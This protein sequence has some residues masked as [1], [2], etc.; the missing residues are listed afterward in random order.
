MADSRDDFGRQI[1][2]LYQHLYDL[3]YLRTHAFTERLIPDPA[4]PR[5]EKAWR[6]H[7]LLLEV[8]KELDPGPEAPAFSR[9]WRRHRLMVLRYVDG[10]DPQ[11]VAREV[12]VSRRQYYREHDAALDA[13]AD[14]LWDR[15]ATQS[16]DLQDVIQPVEKASPVS[17]LELLRLET[18][19]LAQAERYTRV[20]QVATNVL[21]LFEERLRQRA[22]Q[23][24]LSLPPSTPGVSFDRG[25]LRQVL[26]GMLGYLIER[27]SEATIDVTVKHEASGAC[28]ALRVD[29]PQAVREM[30]AAVARERIEAFEEMAALESA[31]VLPVRTGEAIT[32]FDLW[33]PTEL[34]RT[35]L[36]VDDNED[37]LQLFQRYLIP[38]QYRVATAQTARAGLDLAIKLKPDVITLDLMMPEQ[39]GWDLLQALLNHPDTCHIPI[40]VCTV[41]K[42]KELAL[43]LGAAAFLKKPVTEEDLLSIL[44]SLEE[45]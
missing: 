8:I 40:I 25:L 31:R 20:D 2:D 42:Q 21:P 43:S 14:I 32:G 29:P 10:V 41:L 36:A 12:A 15:Y 37:V 24:R 45:T 26:M 35:V 4:I 33:L 22:L 1:T 39:D 9:E 28:L 44:R 5:K 11:A 6:L 27:A 34:Q 38:H 19:R 17:D 23:S 7:D 18:A 16:P 30:D 3:V 13:I